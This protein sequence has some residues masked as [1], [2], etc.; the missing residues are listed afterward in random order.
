MQITTIGIDLAKQV[1][2]LHGVDVHGKTVL[3]NGFPVRRSA[4]SWPT[5]RR[6]VW[7]WKR[8]PARTIGAD[9]CAPSVMTSAS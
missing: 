8:V 5:S 3:K 1:F 4:H 9:S 6:V 2:Q 7:A